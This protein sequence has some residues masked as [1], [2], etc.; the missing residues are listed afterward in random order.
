MLLNRRR[1]SGVSSGALSNTLCLERK[2]N[3]N[4]RRGKETG[5]MERP[6]RPRNKKR[7]GRKEQ[8]NE[9]RVRE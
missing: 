3:R 8:G 7:K 5:K 9:K 4:K 1:I 6:N 2:R